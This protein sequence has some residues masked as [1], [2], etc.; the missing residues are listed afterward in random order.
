MYS[1]KAI[2]AFIISV[3]PLIIGL[4]G[5]LIRVIGNEAGIDIL[6]K[7]MFLVFWFLPIVLVL[8]IISLINI[9]KESNI[10][11]KGLAIASIIMIL[12]QTA[13]SFVLS[14]IA[15]NAWS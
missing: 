7:S 1:K 5:V 4:L 8:A 9:H 10:K 12:I 13:L 3:I 15:A 14:N 6:F 2:W 11:G